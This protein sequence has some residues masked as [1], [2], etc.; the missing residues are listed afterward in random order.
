[1]DN[2]AD[3]IIKGYELRALIGKGGFGAVYRAWQPTLGREVAIKIILP[4]YADHPDFIRRFEAEAQ[5]V[6]RLEHPYI[7]P[8]YDYWR[9]PGGAYLVMRYLRGG[10]ARA[11]LARGPWSPDAAARLL[12]QVAAALS[13]AHRAGVIHRDIKPDNLLLD[14]DD[15]AYLA[16]FGIAKTLSAD[17]TRTEGVVGSPAYLSPE[18]LKGEAVTPQTDLYSLGIVLYELLTGQHPFPDVTPTTLIV[19]HLNEPL[20]S[21]AMVRPDLPVALDR[22]LQKATAKAPADRYPDAPALAAAFHATLAG[23][24]A[25]PVF[26]DAATTPDL[27]PIVVMAAPPEPAN[28]YKG[29]RAFT[30]ADADDFF[31]REALVRQLIARLGEEGDVTRFLA[32]V[33]PSG[34]GKSSA[35]RGRA[36]SGAAARGAAGVRTVVCR[37][38]AAGRASARGTGGGAP[39]CRG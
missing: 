6:A 15:N 35:V 37:G 5:L 32:V 38:D 29:L 4:Q 1:M 36:D 9:E 8:L 14:E 21:L 34:S 19:K 30:E 16:D 18:Q 11:A 27:A 13:A 25:A 24:P 2:P 12:D 3:K 20:P 10:S 23:Q 28:P 7:V 33:G 26:G 39:A 22:V 17:V 31:G